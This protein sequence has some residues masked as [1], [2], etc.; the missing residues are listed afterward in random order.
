MSDQFRELLRLQAQNLQG[1]IRQ[2]IVEGQTT[3]EVAHDD[4]DQLVTAVT[5]CLT[6]LTKMGSHS[7]E[8][9]QKRIPRAEIILRMLKPDGC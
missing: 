2:L 8:L 1:V 7:P 9:F 3:G 6:G 5:A 4:P